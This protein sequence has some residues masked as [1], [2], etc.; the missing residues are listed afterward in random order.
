MVSPPL[1]RFGTF[2]IRLQRRNVVVSDTNQGGKCVEHG[3]IEGRTIRTSAIVEAQ[4]R[5]IHSYLPTDSAT[6]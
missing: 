2:K 6:Y 5:L 1:I 3:E 4:F